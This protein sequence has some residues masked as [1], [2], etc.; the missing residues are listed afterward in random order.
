MNILHILSAPAAGGAEI[1]VKDLAVELTK[2]GHC[3]HLGFLSEAKDIGRSVDFQKRYLDELTDAGIDH[4]IIG[5]SARHQPW[6]GATRVR[7][8]VRDNKIEVYHAHLTYGI[9]F[10]ALLKIP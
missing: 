6:I 8:Y 1:Y 10:G 7:N 2:R 3:V 4:F 5:K 9:V